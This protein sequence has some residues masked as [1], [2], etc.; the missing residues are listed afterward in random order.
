MEEI[1]KYAST[2]RNTL[3]SGA[4]ELMDDEYIKIF[5]FC[6]EPNIPTGKWE[7]TI[8]EFKKKYGKTG[9]ELYDLII[10]KATSSRKDVDEIFG[11]AGKT[12]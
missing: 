9:D 2:Q 8:E 1:A 11:L 4:R 10:D 6:E 5:L 3:R 7:D 12:K